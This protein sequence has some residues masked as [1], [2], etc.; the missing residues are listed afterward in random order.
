MA[1]VRFI[2]EYA[3]VP[4]GLDWE[5]LEE[6]AHFLNMLHEYCRDQEIAFPLQELPEKFNEKFNEC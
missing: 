6:R 3:E 5:D 2:S 4:D 1:W